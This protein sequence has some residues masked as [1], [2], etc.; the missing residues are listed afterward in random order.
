MSSTIDSQTVSYLANIRKITMADIA[1]LTL[2]V[3]DY[4]ISL[5]SEIRLVWGVPWTL[6]KILYLLTRYLALVGAIVTVI[7]DTIQ[8]VPLESCEPLSDAMIYIIFIEICISGDFSKSIIHI[9]FGLCPLDPSGT[10]TAKA[11]LIYLLV[12]EIDGFSYNA[13]ALKT[14]S[15]GILIGLQAALHSILTSRMLLHIHQ[16][17]IDA[18]IPSAQSSQS[19]AKPGLPASNSGWSPILVWEAF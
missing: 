3:Y 13:I 9:K 5:D 15:E 2:V 1:T 12:F 18:S 16:Q 7:F 10:S 14:A 8:F 19:L 17:A 6:G 4:L 11:L